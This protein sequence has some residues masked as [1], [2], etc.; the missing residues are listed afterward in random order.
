MGSVF[1]NKQIRTEIY[2]VESKHDRNSLPCSKQ[3][4]TIVTTK[5]TLYML[6]LV[7]RKANK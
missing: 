1:L 5:T 3:S 6:Y 4:V 2:Y 7:K